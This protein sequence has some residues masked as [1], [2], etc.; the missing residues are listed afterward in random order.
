MGVILLRLT[1]D[2]FTVKETEVLEWILIGTTMLGLPTNVGM[3]Q[4]L[5]LAFR[6]EMVTKVADMA[7][8]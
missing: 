7:K 8:L 2:R 1:G 3:S 6:I 4:P 5:M